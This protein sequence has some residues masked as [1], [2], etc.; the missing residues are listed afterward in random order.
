MKNA[1]TT[2]LLFFSLLCHGQSSKLF[3]TD[4]ELSSSLINQIYQDRNGFIWVATED[5]LN[6]YDGA[7]FTIYKHDPNNEHSLAHSFVRTVFEDSKGHLLIGTYIGIQMYNPDTDDF[8]PL[9]RREDNG[10]I[11]ES[12]I[13]SIIE[14]KNGDVWISGNVLC[15]LY[16][17]DN[18][19]IVQQINASIASPG[20]MIEDK[21][22]N[23]WM[24]QGEE[25]L[26]RLDPDN[27]LSLY[28]S[29]DNGYINS[30]CE[31]SQGNIYVGSMR[32]GL[33][34][35]EP[36]SNTFVPANF[37]EKIELPISF[38]YAASPNEL[39]IGTDGKG[40]NIYNNKT[41][42]LSEYRFD[43]S[44][45]DSSKSKVHSILKDNSGNLWL[46]IY[47]KG[48]IMIP[49][50][51]NSFK[52]IG[53]K[54]MDKNI[55]GSSCITSFCKDY[56]G[57]L[58]IGTD[59]DGIYG[60]SKNM[61]QVKH[62]SHTNHPSSVPS[63]VTRL[64]EDSEHNIWFGSFINGMGKLDKQTGQCS[65]QYKLVDKNNNYIQR[66]YDFAEDNNKRLW[67]ATMGFGL[68]YYDLKTKEFSSVQSETSLINDWINC[69]HYSSDNKLYVGTYD[70]VNCIDINSSDF[71]S[72]KI[73]PQNVIYSIY[74]DTSGII[75][76]GSSEGLSSW[77]KETKKITTYTT[78]NGLPSNTIYAIEGDDDFLW[79]STN[80]GISQF[81]KNNNK[82]IN[83]Y[84]GDGLQGNEFY[85]NASFKDSQGTIWFGGMNGITYFNPQDIINPAKKWNIRITDFFLHNSPVRKGMKSGIHTIIN[86][87]VFKAEEFYLS[88]K[89]NV[90]SIEFATLELN[91]PEHIN[92]LYSI[93]DEKWISLP[94][95]VNRISFSNLKP[96]TYNF[97][98]RAKDNTIY[99]NI[100]EITIFISPAW[101]ASW[102]AKII[103]CLLSLTIIFIIILQIRHRYR[104]HQ[105]MLQHIHAEQINEAKLQ[106]FINISHEIRTPMS[107]IISPL[108]KLIKNENNNERLKIYHIIYRNAERIL[109]LVNQLMDIR[110][111]DKGQMCLM[112][113][114]TNIIPFIED[115]CTTFDQQA[116]TKNIQLQF[117]RQV[118]DLNVW[119][120]T[121]NFDKIILNI[122]SNAFKFTPEKGKIDIT[123]RTG[124]DNTLPEP[125]KQYA[126]IIISDTGTGID[127]EEKEH[128]FERFYQ[129]RN[130][131]Q[132]PKGG[133]GIGLHLTRSLVELH[134]GVIYVENNENQPGCRFIIRLPLGNKHLRPEE[135]ENN[136]KEATVSISTA[137][138]ISPIIE[139]EEEKKV[140]V[141]TKYHVLIVE[142]DEEIRNY[143]AKEFA[144][145]F[146]I[147]ESCNGKEALELIF[148]KTPD[149]VISDIMMPE[150]DGLTLCRKI[151][152]NVNLNHI[153]VIL[154]TAK[155]REE[156]NL[157]GLNTGADAYIMK[158]FNIEILQKTVE[159]LI[160]TRQ[161]LRKVFTGQQNQ[162]NKVQKLEVKSPDEK[163]MERIMKVIN[164]NISNPNLTIET[165]TTEVG[166]SRVHLHRKLKELTNQTTRDFIRNIRLK[167]AARLLSEKQYTISEI[168]T[169][170]G[171]TDPNNFSTTFKELYG[172][173]PSM[174]MKEQLGKKEE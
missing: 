36:E 93:N 131:Q 162:E 137:P 33:F 51:T 64:Y 81:Q 74:E 83:Y 58:W 161:Q 91:A 169:L 112:F 52:Y 57:I 34:V 99:S 3:T 157:E 29:K 31:D 174:Y 45:F 167:E 120:D 32:K 171:F 65:Y 84:V 50:R 71:Q 113:Q 46:A 23:I 154:L 37:K 107:L 13:V 11:F 160:N 89:D 82:F 152:Q 104:M 127:E 130:S 28:L 43:N 10:E 144:D 103:Y 138:I 78:T 134:H 55:I 21:K 90:F 164:E 141:K 67:V 69:L 119:V 14:R 42:E 40:M 76:I 49:A 68:F 77:N 86:C 16:I 88:Y 172:M 73:L 9:A 132:N 123:I 122:L 163:L 98:I 146:H 27:Q 97:K 17:K 117:H 47:Q 24:S 20:Y 18:Q 109:N 80:A 168:A 54:S 126:E 62:F 61:E 149:L 41:N 15:K 111:I 26:Y 166:I 63:T 5:G 135:V 129:I 115:L 121:A 108:Q 145:K 151:K 114:E 102:W 79:I 105:E 38:L 70:G 101:Y 94:K 30:I 148:K 48:V 153:P 75:W 92:Y 156:D 60:I 1:L 118:Q 25:G 133:T 87:P 72:Y 170:T 165:I 159:N 85:K 22:Q 158:P 44:Y 142:D 7:K 143:I 39:Y 4:N 116:N 140:R 2:L 139:N 8:T 128:I 56:N 173:P 136:E 59:N 106:F 110:K 150:M 12:N 147:M 53:H 66:V 125:L 95:G 96:G 6:R 100:K 35:Y 19:L 155:T 124:K